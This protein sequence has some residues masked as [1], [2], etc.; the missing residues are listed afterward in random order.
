MRVKKCVRKYLVK[1]KIIKSEIKILI[2]D[3]IFINILLLVI[4][5]NK[6][7][8]LFYTIENSTIDALNKF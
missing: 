6:D 8:E 3:V 5:Y 4:Y 7:S 2:K 1:V